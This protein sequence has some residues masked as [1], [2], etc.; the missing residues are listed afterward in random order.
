MT[1]PLT[2]W[3]MHTAWINENNRD[4]VQGGRW[5]LGWSVSI[6]RMAW[7]HLGQRKARSWDAEDPG[8]LN[9]DGS[10]IN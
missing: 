2:L 1:K 6:K 10:S 4:R 8:Q 5:R 3:D 9:H 7:P